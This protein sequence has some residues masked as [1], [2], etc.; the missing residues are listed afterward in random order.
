MKRP[1]LQHLPASI[2]GD[3]DFSFPGSL[4]LGMMQTKS[5]RIHDSSS[6]KTSHQPETRARESSFSVPRWRV[7]LVFWKIGM[8]LLLGLPPVY[9]ACF[10]VIPLWESESRS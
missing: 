10:V 7:G 1:T 8:K 9:C 2:D 6:F 3:S 4:H 5:T